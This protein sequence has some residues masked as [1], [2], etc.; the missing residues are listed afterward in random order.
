MPSN[1]LVVAINERT[2]VAIW[3]A[4][5]G[6]FLVDEDGVV[7]RAAQAENLPT[8]FAAPGASLKPGASVDAAGT[9]TLQFLDEEGRVTAALPDATGDRRGG[10]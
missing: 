1:E 9:P 10:P 3:A 2:P 4:P 7:V 5:E 8:V 6:R